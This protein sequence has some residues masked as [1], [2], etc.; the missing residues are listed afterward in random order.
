MALAATAIPARRPPPPVG[1]IIAST[2]GISCI[3]SSA[4]VP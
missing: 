2:S 3:I 4:M 1:T